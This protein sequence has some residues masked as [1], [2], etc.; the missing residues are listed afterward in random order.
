MSCGEQPSCQTFRKVDG[1]AQDPKVRI[2][3][4]SSNAAAYAWWQATKG[5][6][7]G[8]GMSGTDDARVVQLGDRHA[9]RQEAL[10]LVQVGQQLAAQPLDRH[11]LAAQH[12]LLDGREGALP[13]LAALRT[14]SKPD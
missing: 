5:K 3:W 7:D 10:H 11:P 12:A 14:F 2:C 6:D 4:G 1:A 9:L 8:G 13:Q